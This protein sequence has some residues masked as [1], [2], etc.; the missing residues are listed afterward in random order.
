MTKFTDNL[1]RDIAREHGP[2]LARAERPGPGPASFLRRPRV[3]AGGT[4]ALA[5]AGTALGLGLTAPGSTPAAT[6]GAKGG[7]LGR[8]SR[9]ERV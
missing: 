4:L 8:A 9:R 6:G 5:A 7:E 2:A 3:L 1:W